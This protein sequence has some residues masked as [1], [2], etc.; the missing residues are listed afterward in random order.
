MPLRSLFSILAAWLLFT[1]MYALSMFISKEVSVA[2]MVF[3]RNAVSLICIMPWMFYYGKASYTTS[4]PW[5]IGIRAIASLTALALN[6]TALKYTNLVDATM[7]ANT[8]PFFVP[9]LLWA[10]K[11]RPVQKDLLLPILLGLIGVGC[12]LKPGFGVF[13]VGGLYAL[14][15]AL[16]MAIATIGVRVSMR[17]EPL[18]TML[19]YLFLLGVLASLPFALA[20]W[21]PLNVYSIFI[22]LMMGLLAT[23]GQV[24][25]GYSLKFAGARYIA[26]FSYSAVGYSAILE[27]LIW[28]RVPGWLT[29]IGIGIITLSGIFVLL[30]SRKDTA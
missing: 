17:T 8:S 6:F 1:V 19:F 23:L 22:L 4:R 18:Y 13:S 12:I 20:D 26:P 2:Q 30:H 21:H 25:F 5:A 9:F 27:L 14:G 24:F 11:K 15:A 7:L 16:F 3:F 29:L 10:W 28:K